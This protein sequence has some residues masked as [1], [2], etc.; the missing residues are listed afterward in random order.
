MGGTNQD[1]L[2]E[3]LLVNLHELL[4]PLLDIGGLLAGVGIVVLGG[5][6]VVLVV[7]APFDDLL[8]DRLVHLDSAILTNCARSEGR[9][10]AWPMIARGP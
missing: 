7:F 4:V 6:G 3:H 2:E 5:L 8:E 9:T 10:G 1:D